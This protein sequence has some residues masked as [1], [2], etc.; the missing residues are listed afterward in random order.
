MAVILKDTFIP[1]LAKST[2]ILLTEQLNFGT[3]WQIWNLKFSNTNL[4]ISY[5]TKSM[6]ECG[7]LNTGQLP[8]Q[9]MKQLCVHNMAT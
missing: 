9:H 2:G 7:I 8:P 6:W 3:G 1:I 4:A 5:Y